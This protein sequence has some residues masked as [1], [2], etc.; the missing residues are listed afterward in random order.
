MG[1]VTLR[2]IRP[3]SGGAEIAVLAENLLRGGHGS[4]V[5]VKADKYHLEVVATGTG[6]LL[7]AFTVDLQGLIG[8]NILIA[9][10][11]T[12][13]NAAE[14][15]HA[16]TILPNGDLS[17]PISTDVSPPALPTSLVLHGNYPNP[18]VQSTNILFDLSEPAI[19][20]ITVYDLLGRKVVIG[21][22]ESRSAG[23]LQTMEISGDALS[24][25]IYFYR[26]E[27]DSGHKVDTR[28]GSMTR[29]R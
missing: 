5:R 13:T 16:L 12:G 26:L 10:A 2:F 21:Q 20:T 14:G 29:I 7:E 27:V 6:R 9:L 4:F 28:Y 15:L 3:E 8:Q 17:T 18:F 24:S 1:A 11:G 23:T 19:V 25:G 22:P